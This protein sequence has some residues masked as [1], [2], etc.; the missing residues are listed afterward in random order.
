[1]KA[2]LKEE[3]LNLSSQHYFGDPSNYLRE[4]R[5]FV[6]Y[7]IVDDNYESHK[8]GIFYAFTQDYFLQ[9]CCI[10]A[11]S[12]P[13]IIAQYKQ[14]R[15]A[16]KPIILS[17]LETYYLENLH[18]KACFPRV[19]TEDGLM[20]KVEFKE[21]LE[22]LEAKIKYKISSALSYR[23]S[24]VDMLQ[25]Y[26]LMPVPDGAD[27]HTWVAICP[28]C[29]KPLLSFSGRYIAISCRSC[30]LS[31]NNGR[32]LNQKIISIRQ[33]KQLRLSNQYLGQN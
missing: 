22:R 32:D 29:Q 12:P 8:V 20:L 18:Y 25:A 21:F 15:K 33:E 30:R 17:I 9:L 2:L 23:P 16:L 11:G 6:G 31:V 24:V 10:V 7:K 28:N 26:S 1:M 19:V 3:G 5:F 4:F 13:V 14:K 27:D